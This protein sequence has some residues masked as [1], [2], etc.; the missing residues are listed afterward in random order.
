MIGTTAGDIIGSVCEWDNSKTKQ[1]DLFSPSCCFTH[2]GSCVEHPRSV[3]TQ[4]SM[5]GFFCP[6]RICWINAAPPDIAH[7]DFLLRSDY[8][9]EYDN[10]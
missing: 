9:N 4:G 10:T 1:F 3:E 2:T 5:V 7:C 8:N 6:S